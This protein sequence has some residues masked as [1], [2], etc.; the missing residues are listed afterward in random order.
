MVRKIL[1]NIL[2]TSVSSEGKGVGRYENKVV[3]VDKAVPGDVVDVAVT[4]SKAS[5]E[6]GRISAISAE[7]ASRVSPVCTHFGTCGGCSWQHIAYTAQLQFKH[8]IVQN[9]F[10]RISKIPLPEI[11]EV[12]GSEKVYAYRNKLDYTF[13]AR[14]WLSDTEMLNK[15]ECEHRGLGFHLPGMFDKV[16]DIYECHHQPALHNEIRNAIRNYAFANNLS[17][18][19]LKK[20]EGLLRN[21]IV[22]CTSTGEW[23]VLLSFFQ[24]DEA[25]INGILEFLHAKFPQINALLYVVNTKKNETIFD[26]DIKTAWGKDCIY[27]VLGNKT[28]KIGPKS[29]FQTNS[30]QAKQLYDVIKEFCGANGTEVLYDLYCGVG[31]IG[32]YIADSVAQVIGIEEIPA[33]IADAEENARLNKLRNIH[34]YAGD[35]RKLFNEVLV[36]LHGRPDIIITDPPRAG[37]HEEAVAFLFQSDAEKIVYVS[38]NV[39]TQARDLALLHAKYDVVKM[40]P[41]DMFPHTAHIE[42]VA[43]LVKRM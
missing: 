13:S 3:F 5:F 12:L 15:E 18:F 30:Y 11:P 21:L 26:Q 24:N 22:R 7:S 2:I 9:T 42:N 38:C 34:F 1:Q 29:F 19:H 40:Q 27:E 43:L 36:Q 31:S 23:M 4:K 39:A 33:A 17:F 32:I 28:F 14:R 16:L 8:S 20:Q 41:V 37:M 25:A 6:E 10:E 35:V